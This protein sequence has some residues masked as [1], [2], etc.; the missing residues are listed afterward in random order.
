VAAPLFVAADVWVL[1]R[2]LD[3]AIASAAVI[4]VPLALTFSLTARYA[5]RGYRLDSDGL[6][7]ERRA[8]DLVVPYAS[9]RSVDRTRRG[10]LGIGAGSRGFLG[11][12]T[13]GRAWRPGLGRY[14]LCLTNRR[15]VVWVQAADGWIALSPDRPDAFVERLRARLSDHA[16]V[17]RARPS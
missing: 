2:R 17:V 13:L 14:R 11:Y 9:I 7:V 8:S 4:A 12:F 16:S 3:L 1:A 10:L 15:D 6:H 5:P